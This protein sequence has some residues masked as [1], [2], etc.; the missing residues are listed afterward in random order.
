M[1]FSKEELK[2]IQRPNSPHYALSATYSISMTMENDSRVYDEVNR[3]RRID[4]TITAADLASVYKMFK[5]DPDEWAAGEIDFHIL[6]E[7]FNMDAESKP[8]TDTI[9]TALETI[10]IQGN[11]AVLAFQLSA[12]EYPKVNKIIEALGGRWNRKAGGHVFADKD[13]EEQIANYLIT[14]KL[15][16]PE[17]F[18]FFPTPTALAQE[19]VRSAGVEPGMT[20]LEPEAGVGNIALVC[21]DIVGKHHVRCFELQAANC[22]KLRDLGFEVIESDFLKV[23]PPVDPDDLV[24][25][26]VMNPPFEKQADID[27][28]EHALKFLAPG[29][30]FATIMSQSVMFRTNAKTTRFRA[31]LDKV[32]A[33][34]KVNDPAAFRE[35]GTL[36]RTVSITFRK[37]VEAVATVRSARPA[38]PAP[39]VPQP[40]T[41]SPAIPV[42]LLALPQRPQLPVQGAFAF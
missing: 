39:Q 41:S 20:V 25:A 18:G 27:H 3:R 11:V 35:S 28:V 32:G 40:R 36:A 13:P 16:K 17:K 30:R 6:A 23:D 8:I 2:A 21:A 15:D 7:N 42:E 9:R 5:F 26:V 14:G 22:R 29:G 4:G 34:I 1:D 37:P 24:D 31:F 10:T 12:G 19:L 33:T 38:A